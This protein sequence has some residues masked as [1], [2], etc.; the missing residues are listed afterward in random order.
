MARFQFRKREQQRIPL[1]PGVFKDRAQQT[2]ADA[3]SRILTSFDDPT[4]LS[5]RVYNSANQALGANAAVTFD[6]ARFNNGG[7]WS[8]TVASRLTAVQSGIYAVSFHCT[9]SAGANLFLRVNG[10]T[11]IS[12]ADV[13]ATVRLET[14][15]FF[16]QNDYVE[17]FNSGGAVTCNFVASYTPE[18]S[19][20]WL[21]PVQE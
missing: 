2:W 3:I 15:W 13:N 5:A 18:F 17:V 6:T 8:S 10:T 20:H 21:D 12:T 9:L 11:Q 7:L 16:N 14:K 1:N 4:T 19:M